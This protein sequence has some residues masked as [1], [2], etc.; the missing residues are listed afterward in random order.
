[1]TEASSSDRFVDYGASPNPLILCEAD[2][3]QERKTQDPDHSRLDTPHHQ[4]Q[5]LVRACDQVEWEIV[6]V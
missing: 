4:P 2:R 5:A 1:M 3:S 6:G